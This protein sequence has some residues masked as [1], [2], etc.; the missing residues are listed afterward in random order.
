MCE[1]CGSA[2]A[3]IEVSVGFDRPIYVAILGSD[4]EGLAKVAQAFAEKV[5]KIP[6]VVD[7]ESS[8]QQGLPAYAVKLKPGVNV[9][10]VVAREDD[11]FAQR[12]VMTVYSKKGDPLAKDAR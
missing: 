7:V 10:T 6:N 8:V 4:A 12:E 11:E 9:I 5:K 2:I 3:G 1:K